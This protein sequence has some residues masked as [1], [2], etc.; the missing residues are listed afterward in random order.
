MLSKAIQKALNEQLNAEL[1]SSCLYLSMSAYFEAANLPGFAHWMR[2]Q[3]R[4]EEGHGMKFYEHIVDRLGRVKLQAVECPPAEWDSPL[5]AFEAAFEHERLVTGRIDDLVKLACKEVDNAAAAFLQ[6]FV[7]EQVEEE[8][9]TSEIVQK[10][11]LVKE[12]APALL[13]LDAVLGQRGG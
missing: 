8:K 7:T 11:K 12:A 5:A 3:A 2:V 1:Y 6:W 4:E 9:S 13:M 10:L